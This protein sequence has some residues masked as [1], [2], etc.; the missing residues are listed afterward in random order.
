[1]EL[2]LIIVPTLLFY[3]NIILLK[4]QAA[5]QI[6]VAIFP[7]QDYNAPLDESS[8]IRFNCTGTAAII[9]W[10]VDGIPANYNRIVRRGVSITPAVNVGGGLYFS[11]LFIRATHEN[12]NT[13]L[14]CTAIHISPIG[15]K[16]SKQVFLNV[17]G[18][19]GA[20]PNLTISENVGMSL[21]F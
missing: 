18:L 9:Q 5:A 16:S 20:P 7:D 13:S 10:T 21:E 4:I 11:S 8:V 15:S 3:N 2:L 17:Q 19:L 6:T 14:Q 12:S 1:M